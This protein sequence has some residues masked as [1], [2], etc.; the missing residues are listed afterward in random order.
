MKSAQ[1]AR[2]ISMLLTMGVVY[3]FI[4]LAD[5]LGWPAAVEFALGVL[6][7]FTLVGTVLVMTDWS[8]WRADRAR[9]RRERAIRKLARTETRHRRRLDAR[10]GRDA[11]Q[12]R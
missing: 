6:G 3:P 9:L 2:R 1:R 5:V 7:L 12:S 11:R 4:V 8:E 10:R